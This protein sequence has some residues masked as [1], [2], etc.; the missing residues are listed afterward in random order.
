LPRPRPL[1]D[2]AGTSPD[3]KKGLAEL[4]AATKAVS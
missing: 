4:I 3:A 1:A 2:A